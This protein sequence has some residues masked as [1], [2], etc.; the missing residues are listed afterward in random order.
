MAIKLL[1][2]E[3]A[4]EFAQQFGIERSYGS[5]QELLDQAWA[6]PGPS[7]VMPVR[8]PGLGPGWA[9]LALVL[10]FHIYLIDL[11]YICRL[12]LK[13]GLFSY[14]FNNV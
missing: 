8:G 5:Y 2:V 6:Q 12:Q 3:R 7:P 11:G 1:C 14:F 10:V 9:G 4:K 13:R